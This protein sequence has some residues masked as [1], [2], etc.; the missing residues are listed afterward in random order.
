MF[1]YAVGFP[2]VGVAAKGTIHLRVPTT[3]DM[4]PRVLFI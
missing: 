1:N 2:S 4:L 3:I